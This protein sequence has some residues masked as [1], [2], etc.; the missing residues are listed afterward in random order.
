[1][2]HYTKLHHITPH[3]TTPHHTSPHYTGKR[4]STESVPAYLAYSNVYSH[5]ESVLLLWAAHHLEKDKDRDRDRD[6]K[7]DKDRDRDRDNDRD[8]DDKKDKDRDKDRDKM[9]CKIGVK[10]IQLIILI[11]FSFLSQ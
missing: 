6:G 8:R 10:S 3:H 4:S 11:L 9:L 5:Q 1:M 7:K 2:S